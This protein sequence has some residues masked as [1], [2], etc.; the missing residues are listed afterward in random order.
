MD[1]II[2]IISILSGALLLMGLLTYGT[3]F[4]ILHVLIQ[5]FKD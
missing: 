3:I 4:L 5:V 2:N 1:T